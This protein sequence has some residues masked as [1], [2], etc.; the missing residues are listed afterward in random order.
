VSIQY[1]DGVEASVGDR[2]ICVNRNDVGL[3]PVFNNPSDVF[4][5]YALYTSS[6][7]SAGRCD[8]WR[9]RDGVLSPDWFT[10]RF[11]KVGSGVTMTQTRRLTVKSVRPE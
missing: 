4:E 8:I 9:V 7:S 2:V 10:S 6:S 5:V 1:A 11:I 3:D